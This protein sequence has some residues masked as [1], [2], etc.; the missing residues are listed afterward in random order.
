MNLVLIAVLSIAHLFIDIPGSALPVA[1]P[2]LQKKLV[3]NYTQV[4][5]VIMVANLTSSIVQPCLGYFSD[6]M[7]IEWLLPASIAVTYGFFSFIGIVPSYGLLLFFVGLSGAGVAMFHPEGFKMAHYCTGTHAA[8]GMSIFQVGGNVGLAF[9]PLAAAFAIQFA[10]LRGTLLFLPLGLVIFCMILRFI[11]D[12]T[13]QVRNGHQM[14]TKELSHPLSAKERGAW[15][16]MA[17][18]VVAVALRSWAHMGLMTFIPFYYTNIMQGGAISAGHLVFV[19]L[20]GG[21]AG[22]L[23]GGVLSDRVG[24]KYFFALSLFC[25]IPLLFLFPHVSGVWVFVVLFF[26]GFVLI[27]SFS[28]S[29]VMGQTI[30]HDRLGVASGLMLGFVI[31]IGGIGAALLGVV[32]DLWGIATVFRL[33]AIMPALALIPL[34]MLPNPRPNPLLK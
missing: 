2:L 12:L 15:F 4:G 9:G 28:V 16:S 32:A 29:V 17:L 1:M 21:A 19:F 6:R 11:R 26:V 18:L 7:H 23:V 33:I 5:A 14:Q 25:S 20:I 24:H 27:S 31:G 22:T 30:L 34:L 13:N 10:G 3:L 8:T